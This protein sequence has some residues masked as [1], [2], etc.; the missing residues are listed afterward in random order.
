MMNPTLR[1]V[2]ACVCYTALI[3]IALGLIFGPLVCFSQVA[4]RPASETYV[5]AKLNAHNA[6]NNAHS[7]IRAQV[8]AATTN[9]NALTIA[10]TN[11]TEA[12]HAATV[13]ANAAILKNTQQD[14]DISYLYASNANTMAIAN[15]ANTRAQAANVTNAQNGAAIASVSNLTVT[16]QATAN[17]AVGGVTAVS[18]LV[19]GVKALNENAITNET[20]SLAL[21]IIATNRTTI[22]YNPT[23][24]HEWTD[25]A[26]RV[27]R[28]STVTNTYAV[29]SVIIDTPISICGEIIQPSTN[30]WPGVPYPLWTDSALSFTQFITNYPAGSTQPMVVWYYYRTGSASPHEVHF[31]SPAEESSASWYSNYQSAS[32]TNSVRV[33]FGRDDLS[34][35]L[36]DP[37]YMVYGTNTTVSVVTSQVATVAWQSDLSL[38][39]TTQT[40]AAALAPMATTQQVAEA[41]SN[42][43][44]YA[45]PV[46]GGKHELWMKE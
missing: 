33:L 15:L 35:T 39:A 11:A 40:L 27:W 5:A 12:A 45:V 37:V 7:D 8:F 23:N 38:Y 16:A 6:T 20:D 4:G 25:G 24:S 28:V 17:A 31:S 2:T 22:V 9:V 10:A 46:I 34:P 29:W 18:N 44:L 32:A 42:L 1:K 19:I 30:Q 41:V 21:S 36:S 43:N 3:V 13:Q 14:A 26:K